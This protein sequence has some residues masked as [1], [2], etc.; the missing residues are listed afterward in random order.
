MSKSSTKVR[1]S[2]ADE[3]RIKNWEPPQKL[4]TPPPPEGFQYRWVRRELTG[5]EEDQNVYRRQREGYEVVRAEEIQDLFPY[6]DT[7]KEGKHTGVVR[8][9]DLILMKVPT[10]IAKQRN[11]YYERAAQTQQR[12][13]N[14]ELGQNDSDVMPLE[15]AHKSRVIR[16]QPIEE[17]NVEFDDE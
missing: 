17:R 10:K 2:R 1:E 6:I 16:G 15:R 5:T 7:V 14:Q 12:A 13:V 3:Q 8:N 11:A 9:G 4:E